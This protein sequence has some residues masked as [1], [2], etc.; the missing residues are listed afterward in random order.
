M[1]I[2]EEVCLKQGFKAH[3]FDLKHHN[4]VLDT[5]AIIRFTGL[6]NNAQLEMCSVQRT[7]T[8]SPVTLGLQLE[9][10]NRLTGDF[11]PADT[12][13]DVIEKLCAEE[14]KRKENLVIIYMRNEVY[15]VEALKSTSLRS[16][17]LTGGRAMLRVIHKS[18]EE[19]KTQANVSSVIP[20]K[21]V[22]EKP[23]VRKQ[24]DTCKNIVHKTE[25]KSANSPVKKS[26]NL[27]MD[28]IKKEKLKSENK[29]TDSN[30]DENMEVEP[31]TTRLKDIP[32]KETAKLPTKIDTRTLEDFVFVS[33]L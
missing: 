22:E 2:L 21:P 15:G 27:V 16:L 12:L 23:Y 14:T 1:Q 20:V 7:R 9:N 17:G 13:W 24:Q 18:P 25:E 32:T 33:Y 8:E 19:L 26:N 31:T 29:V 3:E 10:G 30:Q 5:T 11:L 28:F 4:H 6:P